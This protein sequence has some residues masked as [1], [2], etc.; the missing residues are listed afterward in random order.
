MGEAHLNDLPRRQ[1]AVVVMGICVL[2]FIGGFLNGLSVAGVF[3]IGL[4]HL[5]G[6]TTLAGVTLGSPSSNKRPARFFFALIGSYGIG[7]FLAGLIVGGT[8]SKWRGRQALTLTIEAAA[9]WLAYILLATTDLVYEPAWLIC[10]ACGMQNASTSNLKLIVVR[11]TNV[12]GT[13]VDAFLAIAQCLREGWHEHSWKLAIWFPCLTAFWF[14]AL[15]GTWAWVDVGIHSAIFPACMITLVAAGT[16]VRAILLKRARGSATGL[17]EDDEEAGEGEAQLSTGGG[18]G[19]YQPP[20]HAAA[21]E[22][23]APGYAMVR[24]SELG[25]GLLGKGQM[26]VV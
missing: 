9:L 5:T 10:A 23:R 4:T 15:C 7:A 3:R 18:G 14:G 19:R 2:A 25:S 6:T 16:W 1:F 21:D 8:R 24:L 26:D 11:T 20:A 22:D 13:V 12:T 17:L